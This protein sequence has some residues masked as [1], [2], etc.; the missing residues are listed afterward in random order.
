MRSLTCEASSEWLHMMMTKKDEVIADDTESRW[1]CFCRLQ[2]VIADDAGRSGGD[3]RLKVRRVV[4]SRPQQS[5]QLHI[6]QL[7]NMSVLCNNLKYNAAVLYSVQTPKYSLKP[8]LSVFSNWW[9]TLLTG[10]AGGTRDA[11]WTKSNRAL[12]TKT[13]TKK[14]TKTN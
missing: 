1:W 14:I 2:K 6:T 3:Y 11:G 13:N 8:L 9:D 4:L 10:L 7:P 5:T 12:I